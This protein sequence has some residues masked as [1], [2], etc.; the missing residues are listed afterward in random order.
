[1]IGILIL[2]K[3]DRMKKLE[4]ISDISMV[5]DL[6]KRISKYVDK[7]RIIEGVTRYRI[8]LSKENNNSGYVIKTEHL[9]ICYTKSTNP[10]II[11]FVDKDLFTSGKESLLTMGA[12]NAIVEML[13]ALLGTMILEHQSMIKDYNDWIVAITKVEKLDCNM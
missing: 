1:M 10:V 7:D 5:E 2:R 9:E 13:Q 12:H 4:C 11:R 8:A 6:L 3:G